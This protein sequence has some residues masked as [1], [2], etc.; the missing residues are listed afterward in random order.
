MLALL[1]SS[2]M[3]AASERDAVWLA[4]CYIESRNDPW[5][6]NEAEDAR[7][8]AQIR[9]IMVKDCNRIVGEQRWTHDDAYNPDEARAMFDTFCDHYFPDGDAETWARAWNSGPDMK[10]TDDYW[11]LVKEEMEK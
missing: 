10:N 7:G 9:A 1:L 2:L 3:F 5:A 11:K 8:I 6:L 4:I